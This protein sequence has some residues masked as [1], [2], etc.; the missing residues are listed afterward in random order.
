MANE[1]ALIRQGAAALARKIAAGEVSSREVTRAFLDRIEQVDPALNAVTSLLDEDALE[2]AAE[3]DRRQAAGEP[4]GP[5]HG[6]PV[7][8]KECFY[9][10]GCD[11]TVGLDRFLDKPHTEDCIHVKRLKEAGAIVM[12]HT[13]VPQLMIFH[14]TDNPIYGRTNNPWN[15]NRVPGG[16]TG[17]EAALIAAGGS[18]LGLGGDLGGSIRL[19]CN[20]CGISGLKPTS[21]R[22]SRKGGVE[23]WRGMDA[24]QYQPGP[25][26]RFVADLFPA[27]QALVGDPAQNIEPDVTTAPLRDPRDVDV[28]KLKIGYWTTDE[29]F[30]SSPAAARAVEEAVQI[31]R[32]HGAT[33]EPFEPVDIPEVAEL[34]FIITGA[35]GGA[36]VERVAGDSELDWRVKRLRTI[37]GMGRLMRAFSVQLMKYTA[38]PRRAE[39]VRT[40]RPYSADEYWQ[41]CYRIK[42]L[43]NRFN[44]AMQDGGFDAILNPAHALPAL[45]HGRGADLFQAAANSF[46]ANVLAMP[47]GVTPLTR[48]REDEQTSR[49]HSHDLIE[50]LAR[51]TDKDS[52]GLPVGIQM[53]APAWR[54][55][56]VLATMQTI[57]DAARGREDY[58]AWPGDVI[59]KAADSTSASD[60][61]TSP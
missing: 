25:M 50:T 23:G 52:A 16:S 21:G 42:Q 59:E 51:Q 31:F 35:D 61:P 30:A 41:A 44:Q 49:P 33:V 48:V 24:I 26:S 60:E 7:T 28:S 32:D 14:E 9:V 37:A 19:P 45:R 22:L 54:E 15:L 4:L 34:F 2:D 18:P 1:E 47:A 39:L 38:N 56:I 3:A 29:Y 57:E 11:S 5:L 10:E 27:L 36:D 17:G 40:I 6:V 20:W 8:I 58:P 43:R 55:D 46:L 13:N 53:M 12:A